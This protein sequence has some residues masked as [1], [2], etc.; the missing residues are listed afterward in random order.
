MLQAKLKQKQLNG[1]QN[2][3]QNAAPSEVNARRARRGGL[4]CVPTRTPSFAFPHAL[5]CSVSSLPSSRT[6]AHGLGAL[7][8]SLSL[9]LACIPVVS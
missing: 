3:A 4:F 8:A 2:A 6:R 7:L 1:A 9:S 5:P